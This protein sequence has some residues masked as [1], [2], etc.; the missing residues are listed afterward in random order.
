[1]KKLRIACIIFTLFFVFTG[2]H[3]FAQ[4]PSFA[5]QVIKANN[6]LKTVYY[7]KFN[8]DEQAVLKRGSTYTNGN[9]V[10]GGIQHYLRLKEVTAKLVNTEYDSMS[11]KRSD[12]LI[13]GAVPGEELIITGNWTHAGPIIVINDGLLWFHNANA[14]IL[15][16]IFTIGSGRLMADS[17]YI[18]IPQEY[19]YQR[20][21]IVAENSEMHIRNSTIDFGGLS[22][23]IAI[24]HNGLLVLENVIKPDFSTIGLL[25]QAA[26]QID[27]IDVAGEFICDHET[28]LEIDNAETVLIWH[29]FPEGSTAQLDFP[30]GDYVI[31]YVFD[32]SL[33]N[34]TGINYSIQLN[35]C[36]TV[37]WGLMPSSETDITISNSDMRVIGLWFE[38]NDTS[39]VKGL[40]NNSYY[41][42]WV[43]PLDDRILRLINSNVNTWSIYT[44]DLVNVSL[45]SCII[46]E[47]GAMGQSF[48]EAMFYYCDGSGGY[49]WGTDTTF[50]LNGF[51]A[52]TSSI[53]SQGN[54]I[55]I[56]AY[57]SL[58]NGNAGAVDNSVLM[59]IQSNIDGTPFYDEGSAVWMANINEPGSLIAGVENQIT[60][61]VWIDK[62]EMSNLMD[63]DYYEMFY[64]EASDTTTWQQIGDRVFTEVRESNLANWMAT[65]LEPGNYILKLLVHDDLGN[66]ME[67]FK[68]VVLLPGIF[69]VEEPFN[70]V[71]NFDIYPNPATGS[72]NIYV[73]QKRAG[74]LSIRLFDILGQEALVLT[75][76]Y[77]RPARYKYHINTHSLNKGVYICKIES[78]AFVA[79]QKVII[80]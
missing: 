18:F 68:S 73:N 8:P 9:Y 64:Q 66:S 48:V 72:F 49:V 24:A 41:T 7:E 77:K 21:I 36:K 28:S 27:G 38:G 2:N 16:N 10:T 17:S 55:A 67:A 44:L 37:W 1:M 15:G 33:P 74:R 46:G 22:N 14:I 25:G 79:T 65:A 45:E 13:V 43:M 78:G 57:S 54:G 42:D 80:R 31:N 20:E 3:S 19:F 59:L 23:N 76:G 4:L 26:I 40:V 51:S 58:T 53:R 5:G 35:N 75:D 30:D 71:F 70:E 6:L 50:I 52:L 11:V 34:V 29:R 61:S 56:L 12:T 63:F 60:G 62:G 39:Q 69:G 47:I 32:K